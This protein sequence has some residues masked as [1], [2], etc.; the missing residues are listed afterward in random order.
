MTLYEITSDIK[1]LEELIDSSVIDADGNVKEL[2]DEDKEALNALVNEI[3]DNFEGK[4]ERIAKFMANV[5]AEAAAYKAEEERLY[6]RRK[7]A[8]RKAATLKWLLEDNMKRAGMKKVQAGVFTLSIQKN[9]PS[10]WIAS[11]KDIPTD[12]WRIIPETREPDK[13]AL[14]E[15]LKSGIEIE[16]VYIN[17]NEGLRVR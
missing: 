12:Y 4:A 16:G 1:A 7:T 10:V 11:D 17:Q 6:K 15:A 2:S 3:Q 5:Q 8:E 14:L 9:P 13:K